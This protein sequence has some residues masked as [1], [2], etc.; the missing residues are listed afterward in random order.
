MPVR[1][2]RPIHAHRVVSAAPEAVFALLADLAAHWGLADR[3]TEVLEL[4]E[5]GGTIRLRGPAGLRRTARVSVSRR[6]RPSL[7]EGEARLGAVTR[8]SVRWEL[9]AADGGTG[10]DGPTAVTL[11]AI[12]ERATLLDRALLALGGRRWLAWRFAVTLRR[13]ERELAPP[14]TRP[15]PATEPV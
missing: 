1:P 12:V 3:W 7:I 9:A 14:A 11:T 5:D 6:A 13:L 8:A 2:P 15:E 4:D 10:A